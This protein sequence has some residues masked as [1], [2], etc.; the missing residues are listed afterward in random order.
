[1]NAKLPAPA[2]KHAKAPRPLKI[3]RKV[4]AA[5]DAMVEEGL[6]RPDAAKKAGLTDHALYCA[7]RKPHV[8][9]AYLGAC[10]VL[11][12]SGKARRIHRLAELAEQNTNMNAAVNAIRAAEGMDETGPHVAPGGGPSRGGITIV[13]MQ[14]AAAPVQVEARTISPG[15]VIDAEPLRIDERPAPDFVPYQ[16]PHD[17]SSAPP[18]HQAPPRGRSLRRV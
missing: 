14:P 7:L 17:L 5:I 13:V 15:H 6:I 12:V 3:T 10:E 9:A 18:E 1:M 8:K 11:R 2:D 16:A 4:A